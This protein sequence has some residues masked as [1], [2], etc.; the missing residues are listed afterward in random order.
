[1]DNSSVAA[2]STMN[3]GTS[4]ARKE[5]VRGNIMQDEVARTKKKPRPDQVR[6]DGSCYSTGFI[7]EPWEA[8]EGFLNGLQD[9]ISWP[10]ERI[11]LTLGFQN[12]KWL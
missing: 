11:S 3:K 4:V 12:F 5:T 2:R 9:K 8:T 1:M 10:L 6:C 7:L